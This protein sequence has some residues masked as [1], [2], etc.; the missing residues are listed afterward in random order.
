MKKG[1]RGAHGRGM[2]IWP[3]PWD[4]FLLGTLS[5]EAELLVRGMLIHDEQLEVTWRR[6]GKPAFSELASRLKAEGWNPG[7]AD[8]FKGERQLRSHKRTRV[9]LHSVHYS[10][11]SDVGA[12]PNMRNSLELSGSLKGSKMLKACPLGDVYAACLVLCRESGPWRQHSPEKTTRALT[13]CR[14]NPE[15]AAC[16]Q[17][18][19][20]ADPSSLAG[21]PDHRPGDMKRR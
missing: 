14:E 12:L 6:T 7:F 18:L 16:P 21:D 3:W 1:A 8:A 17:T 19:G 9:W 10:T 11:G 5:L 15:L 2:C 4:I 13:P 20:L